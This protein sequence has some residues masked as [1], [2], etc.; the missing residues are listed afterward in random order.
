[1]TAQS[2]GC[3]WTFIM[4][5]PNL[6]NMI[7]ASRN[8]TSI[9]WW[10]SHVNLAMLQRHNRLLSVFSFQLSKCGILSYQNIAPWT[11]HQSRSV[12][13]ANGHFLP[14]F[15]QNPREIQSLQTFAVI[16]FMYGFYDCQNC[17]HYHFPDNSL[18]LML[19][20]SIDNPCYTVQQE[21]QQEKHPNIHMI[22]GICMYG[23]YIYIH[24]DL[25]IFTQK[26]HL[27]VTSPFYHFFHQT[28]FLRVGNPPEH[29]GSI[30]GGRCHGRHIMR[31]ATVQNSLGETVQL[32]VMFLFHVHFGDVIC[33]YLWCVD[34]ETYIDCFINENISWIAAREKIQKMSLSKTSFTKFSARQE[35]ASWGAKRCKMLP[36][37]TDQRR[38]QSY[39][40]QAVKTWFTMSTWGNVKQCEL[41]NNWIAQ[42]EDLRKANSDFKVTW[43]NGQ[44][45]M[46]KWQN[47][48]KAC[49]RIECFWIVSKCKKIARY[50]MIQ[51]GI[52]SY[53]QT[54]FKAT[55]APTH[56]W[57]NFQKNRQKSAQTS[58]PS[59]HQVWTW[60][61]STH[62][63]PEL[64]CTPWP[65]LAQH[66]PTSLE[67]LRGFISP[68]SSETWRFLFDV[69]STFWLCHIPLMS[70]QSTLPKKISIQRL[71]HQYSNVLP[72]P[73]WYI[74][75]AVHW[76]LSTDHFGL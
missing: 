11:S 54:E 36:V 23:I 30:P 53:P 5:C 32:K 3:G 64:I 55:G 41:W 7:D 33:E 18:E 29:Q 24:L 10:E 6:C 25:H 42:K 65:I 1:M 12:F 20:D 76:S 51:L 34:G 14:Q 22:L 70:T 40:E 48:N 73:V 13:C 67:V 43:E 75:V 28:H 8:D 19:W 63:L 21:K 60:H 44:N 38:A 16:A 66:P 62:S 71:R 50:N 46:T 39:H 74:L 72:L 37:W 68:F 52:K 27:D 47:H 69:S 31:N 15:Q 59:S 2:H 45:M 57:I 4:D 9:I 61:Y 49:E 17:N 56:H 26:K 58:R 35:T